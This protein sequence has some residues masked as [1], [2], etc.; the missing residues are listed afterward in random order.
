MRKQK[1]NL[2]WFITHWQSKNLPTAA[3]V[4]KFY[5]QFK[6]I[7]MFTYIFHDFPFFIIRVPRFVVVEW[8]PFF[9]QIELEA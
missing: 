5:F 6:L 8:Q 2:I 1:R 4:N 3:R 9:L 7:I